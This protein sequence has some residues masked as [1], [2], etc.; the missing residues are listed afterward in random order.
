[1]AIALG[2]ALTSGN[3]STDATS[4]ATASIT[5]DTNNLVLV[6]VIS[7]RA[8]A[9][10]SAP[11]ITNYTQVA[12]VAFATIGTE[13]RR[14][15]VFRSLSASPA[16]GALTISFGAETQ[17]SCAWSVSQFS[18][19]DIGGTNGANAVVQSVTNRMDDSGGDDTLAVTL[20]AFGHANNATYG[21]FGQDANNL[22][23]PGSGFTQ[24]H[25]V[26]STTPQS[27]VFSEYKIAN[28]TSVDATETVDGASGLGGIGIEIKA[29]PDTVTIE[30]DTTLDEV[31][32]LLNLQ[33]RYLPEIDTV[34]DKVQSTIRLDM[35]PQVRI[36]TVLDRVLA[37]I[38]VSQIDKV[39]IGTTIKPVR[40][41]LNLAMFAF[42]TIVTT[43]DRVQ[44]NI[45]IFNSRLQIVTVLRPVRI[46]ITLEMLPTVTIQVV[47]D[48]VQSNI[49]VGQTQFLT[50]NTTL[51][52]VTANLNIAQIYF[53]TIN[54][55]LAKVGS[56]IN[57]QHVHLL[58]IATII[59]EV[60]ANINAGQTYFL[61]INTIVDRVVAAINIE[62]PY[63]LTINTI[64]DEVQ[65]SINVTTPTLVTINTVLDR[66]IA[67]ILLSV[68]FYLD[69]PGFGY[70]IAARLLNGTATAS[71]RQH[72]LA[73]ISDPRL[74]T[75]RASTP[76]TG[77]AGIPNPGIGSARRNSP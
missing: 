76:N 1:M 8:S 3:S 43:I 34:I 4:Y 27:N 40:A 53:L 9:V 17:T 15:T 69:L 52:R 24:I 54:T 51:D 22:F 26:V 75:G 33:Q 35:H 28:D 11:T 73:L 23:V 58:T 39:T 25:D 55:V 72:G 60:I 57:L 48:R 47:L 16:T 66:V 30:V 65:S 21:A 44:A 64:L 42:P 2:T 50:I 20:A 36:A 49:N 45:N 5:P 29:A 37:L 67:S 56:S 12:T 59:K 71:D 77:N 31:S 32:A 46:S 62:Q 74:G 14:L 41:S 68:I 18:G 61:T 38:N 13:R 63:L 7:S 19:V 6:A 70:A 10:P